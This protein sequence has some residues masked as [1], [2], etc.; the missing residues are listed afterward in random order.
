MKD[1]E[2]DSSFMKRIKAKEF[3]VREELIVKCHL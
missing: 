3:A 2:R 1:C